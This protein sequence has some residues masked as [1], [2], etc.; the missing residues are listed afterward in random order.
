MR[1]Q[2][3]SVFLNALVRDAQVGRLVP[4]A[5]QR[6]YV[7]GRGDV[8]ALLESILAGYPLGGFLLW[9]PHGKADLSRAGRRRLGPI[10]A[11]ADTKGI[12]LLLDGQNRLATMAWMLRDTSQPLPSDLTDHE[13]EVWGGPDQLMCDLHAQKLRYVAPDEKGL[14]LPIAAVFDSRQAQPMIRDRWSTAWSAFSENERDNGLR[15]FDKVENAFRD[16][17]V[18]ATDMEYATAQEAKD[19]F[20]HICR[21]GVPMAAEDFDKALSWAY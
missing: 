9:S 4:A 17:R 18:V 15:W 21:V 7:W 12:S 2:Q 5:F 14:F 8:L 10:E 6:P 1:I 19:A 13:R 16:A 20:T 11:S 3:H